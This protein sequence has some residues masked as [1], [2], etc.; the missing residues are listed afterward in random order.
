VLVFGF[1]S[2][3]L[4]QEPGD[5]T[6]RWLTPRTRPPG[7]PSPNAFGLAVESPV[8]PLGPSFAISV[9]APPPASLHVVVDAGDHQVADPFH[10]SGWDEQAEYDPP[11][12]PTAMRLRRARSFTVDGQAVVCSTPCTGTAP[13]ARQ[14]GH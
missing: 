7:N 13:S 1:S 6:G 14:A 10:H 9:A 12:Y 4:S 5:R 2:P 11:F 8:R 3:P